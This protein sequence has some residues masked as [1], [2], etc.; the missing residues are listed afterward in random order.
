MINLKFTILG[1][2]VTKKNS[3]RII[4]VKTKSGKCFHKIMPSKAFEK[5]EKD[6]KYQMP[7]IDN[8][9]SVPI[10]LKCVYYMESRR[11]IDL[12]NVLNATADILVD[13]G[14]LEDDNRNIVYSTDGSKVLYDK[15]N[16]RVEVEILELEEGEVEK[17]KM[18][19]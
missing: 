15:E 17:W 1:N 7:K 12:L 9:I 5:Y 3:Q 6:C 4:K 11:K 10:N 13:Y 18:K 19:L 2:P 16:P 8:P 14:V